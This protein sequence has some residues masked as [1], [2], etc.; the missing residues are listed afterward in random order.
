MSSSN[1]F[2]QTIDISCEPTRALQE[3]D[4]DAFDTIVSIADLNFATIRNFVDGPINS[5]PHFFS[6]R[7]NTSVKISKLL[8]IVHN[9]LA[10]IYSY[11]ENLCEVLP[12]Y[13]PDR[14]RNPGTA[15]FACLRRQSRTPYTKK[16]NFILG[17]RT[18]A[19]HGTFCGFNVTNEAWDEDR[20]KHHLKFDRHGFVNA[21]RLNDMNQHLQ[22]TNHR[23]RE[24][25]L[26][27]LAR[28]HTGTFQAFHDDLMNWFDQYSP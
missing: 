23:E 18:D 13:L 2:Q 16:F 21:T 17:L 3:D 12:D 27:F 11:N 1:L 5:D 15:D 26:V 6:E 28:F 22:H 7:Q 20:R 14:V 25:I 10:T 19:Q 8:A 4:G 24:Y 9:Y